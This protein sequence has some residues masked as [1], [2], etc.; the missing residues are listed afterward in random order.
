MLRD[1]LL[2]PTNQPRVVRSRYLPNNDNN[3]DDED[4]LDTV[5][6]V[7]M[8]TQEEKRLA[9]SQDQPGAMSRATAFVLR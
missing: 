4:D 2:V 7:E 3:N 9:G 1:P 6:R 8:D 5:C